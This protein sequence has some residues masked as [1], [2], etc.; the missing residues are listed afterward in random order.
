[1]AGTCLAD[2]QPL[3]PAEQEVIATLRSG[4]FDRLGHEAAGSLPET[5]DTTRTVR[6]EFLRFLLLGGED[7]ARPH[8][9]GIR[10]QGVGHRYT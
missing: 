6:A 8:E 1:M 9:K 7:G 3:L 4:D 5:E 10:V 2:F